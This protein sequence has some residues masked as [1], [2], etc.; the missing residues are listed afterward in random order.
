MGSHFNYQ[1]KF[2]KAYV[3]GSHLNCLNVKAIQMS[4]P[5]YAIYKEVDNITWTAI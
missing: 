2:I 5:T 3:V 1:D 4:I